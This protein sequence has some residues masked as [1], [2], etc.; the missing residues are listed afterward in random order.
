MPL[1]PARGEIDARLSAELNYFWE[2]VFQVPSQLSCK[3]GEV[4]L[5]SRNFQLSLVEN[6]LSTIPMG[7][8]AS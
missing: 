2:G 3:Q 7:I 5:R 1:P 8:P 4:N 6:S